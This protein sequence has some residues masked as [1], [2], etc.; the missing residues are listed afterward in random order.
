[1]LD[2][3][4]NR[5][6]VDATLFLNKK[7]DDLLVVQIYVDDIIFGATNDS[8]CHE[9]AELMKS[10]FKISMMEKLSFFLSLQ[11]SPLGLSFNLST[12]KLGTTRG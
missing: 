12:Y 10:E 8:S 11:I 2:N 9:F 1:M 5:G 7:D 4:F 6:N 3:D